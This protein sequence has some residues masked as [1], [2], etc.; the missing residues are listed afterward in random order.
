MEQIIRDLIVN[1]VKNYPL[2]NNTKTAW[3]KPIVGYSD[4]ENPEFIKLKEIISKEHLTPQEILPT[5]KSVVCYFLPF[6]ENIVKSNDFSG[7]ASKEWAKAYVETNNMIKNLNSYL[8]V[9][10]G[11][12]GH[13]CAKIPPTHNFDTEKLI[14]NWSHRHVAYISGLGT[15]GINNM[16]ITEKGCSGRI[17]SIVT[18]IKLIPTEK[19]CYEYC[20]Y[21]YNYSC[22]VCIEKCEKGALKIN[23][24]NRKECYKACLL[25]AK[26]YEKIG[27]SDVCGKCLSNIP[28]SFEN[29][30]KK[31]KN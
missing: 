3:K 23:K 2:E 10:L 31:L 5:S 15:F 16:L 1:F 12:F 6:A 4:A 8:S 29:P 7:I 13:V 30:S 18:D 25:N 14:S 28:C 11:K 22:G 17:G 19:P 27:I 9:E 24:F 20:L 21:K 26:I